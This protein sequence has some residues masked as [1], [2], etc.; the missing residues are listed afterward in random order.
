[1]QTTFVNEQLEVTASEMT[2]QFWGVRGTLPVPGEKS[3]RYGGNTNCVTLTIA[4][5]H[6]FIFDA[7]TGIKELSNSIVKQARFPLIA[8]IFISHPHYDHINGLPFFVPLFMK[9]NEFEIFG[10]NQG[11]RNI[12]SL[13]SAQMDGIY[14]PFTIKEFAAKVRFHNL[15]EEDF[16]IEN[17]HIQTLFLNHP[18]QC[19]GYR[20]AYAAKVFCYITDNELYLENAPQFSQTGEDRLIHF[21]KD[22]DVL[23]I[24]ATY[25]D[26]EY[27]QKVGWG[28]SAIS[29]V[30]D[31]ADKAKVKLLCLFHHDPEQDDKDIDAKLKQARELLKKRRSVTRCIA[32]SEGELLEL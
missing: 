2:V 19:L 10:T 32:P 7:G 31:L 23:V 28:H 5:K 16:F 1:M 26:E 15:A 21:I 13:I 3:L 17:I 4:K 27:M 11:E 29:R 22:C 6:F 18:G 30:V 14:L 24:D 25:T 12:E 9:E 8:K 20:V